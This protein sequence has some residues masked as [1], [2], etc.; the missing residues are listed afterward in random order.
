MWRETHGPEVEIKLIYSPP[1]EF[2]G[3][4]MH[5]E[6]MPNG[7]VGMKPCQFKIEATTIDEA[8][9]KFDETAR[10]H[11]DKMHDDFLREQARSRLLLPG[12]KT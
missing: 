1:P 4:E 7:D 9:A 12:Q 2:L 11:H 10:P 6:K 5:T 8:W 3:V